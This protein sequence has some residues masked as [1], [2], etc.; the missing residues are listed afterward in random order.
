MAAVASGARQ[1]FV[2][3]CSRDVRREYRADGRKA[4]T[5]GAKFTASKFRR[6]TTDRRTSRDGRG[7]STD[8]R[9]HCRARRAGAVC[10]MYV[11]QRFLSFYVQRTVGASIE[12][13][14]S[15]YCGTSVCKRHDI[16][17]G[18]FEKTIGR[19]DYVAFGHRI[20]TREYTEISPK[21]F[22]FSFDRRSSSDLTASSGNRDTRTFPLYDNTC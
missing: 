4:Y 10:M 14:M 12:R 19:A 13:G 6:R 21:M 2:P 1:K 11:G 20:R 8:G 16:L 9:F 7:R 18:T 5:P 3:T 17:E 22:S 15:I